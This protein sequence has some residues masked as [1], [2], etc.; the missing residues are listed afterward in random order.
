[1]FHPSNSPKFISRSTSL[2]VHNIVNVAHSNTVTVDVFCAT[3]KCLHFASHSPKG[4]T[5]ADR[6]TKCVPLLG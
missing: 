6:S 5:V 1:M 3:L 4:G 2:A